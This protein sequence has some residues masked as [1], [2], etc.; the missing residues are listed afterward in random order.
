MN[1]IF[2]GLIAVLLLAALMFLPACQPFVADSSGEAARGAVSAEV[3]GVPEGL[4]VE[5]V[6]EGLEVPWDLAFTP[7]GRILI[8]ERPGRIRVFQDGQLLPEPYAV[9]GVYHRSEAGLMGI[10]LH[11][12]FADNGYLYVCYTY[13][14]GRSTFNRIARLTDRSDHATDHHV[15]LDGI[16]GASRHDG[17]RLRF[18]ADGYLY[19][20]TGDATEP[21]LAQDLDS[22]AGKVLTAGC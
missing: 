1:P 5:T 21:D 16:P 6:A 19:A 8:T 14:A 10:A 13:R 22:L 20:T 11:P 18:G 3:V 7:D 15:I 12:D 4:A 2:T 9:I 17:C